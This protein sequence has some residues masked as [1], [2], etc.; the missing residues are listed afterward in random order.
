MLGTLEGG[1]MEPDD[2]LMDID[3]QQLIGS[4]TTTFSAQPLGAGARRAPVMGN[5]GLESQHRVQRE[6][7]RSRT[8]SKTFPQKEKSSSR[9]SPRSSRRSGAADKGGSSGS[10]GVVQVAALDERN[11]KKAVH[12][13]GTLPKGAR[14]GAY[15]ESLR[16]SGMTPEPVTEQ[17]VDSDATIDSG[18]LGGGSGADTLERL[19]GGRISQNSGSINMG[20]AV[21][22]NKQQQQPMLR[23]NSSHGGFVS[24]NSGSLGGRGRA[25]PR[26]NPSQLT[27]VGQQG[28]YDHESLG[29][30]RG[31]TI[32]L[33]DLEFPP[34][35]VDLP[36]PPQSFQT[37]Q[38]T[39]SFKPNM[40]NTASDNKVSSPRSNR[41][42][43]SADARENGQTL[44]E[45]LARS[46]LEKRK[47]LSSDSCDS[48]DRS[49]HPTN[50]LPD[51]SSQ[52]NQHNM[53]KSPVSPP[54]SDCR[55]LGSPAVGSLSSPGSTFDEGGRMGI[56]RESSSN[57]INSPAEPI[58]PFNSFAG[59]SH[60]PSVPFGNN[61]NSNMETKLLNEIR[62]HSASS[63]PT[64][65][66]PPAEVNARASAAT[67]SP[68][69]SPTHNSNN[70]GSN[71]PAAMLVTELFETIKAKSNTP[72]NNRI[73]TPEK[74]VESTLEDDKHHEIDFKANLRKVKKPDTKDES[75]KNVTPSTPK[76]IDF[77]SQ[78]K[79]TESTYAN[80]EISKAAVSTKKENSKAGDTEKSLQFGEKISHTHAT[81]ES[82]TETNPIID[83][84]SKLRKSTSKPDQNSPSQDHTNDDAP[85]NFQ[86][87][88]RKVSGT[89]KAPNIT[90]EQQ[91]I[92][93]T[94]KSAN[95]V[96]KRTTDSPRCTTNHSLKR[97][98]VDS[99]DSGGVGSEPGDDKRKSTGSITS[100][101]KMWETGKDGTS[102]GGNSASKSPSNEEAT[103]VT[104]QPKHDVQDNSNLHG[105]HSTVKFEKR[106]WPPVPNTETEK[107][108][109]PVKPTVKPTPAPPTT[110]P[111]PPKEPAPTS[112][113]S[114]GKPSPPGKPP[115]AAKP[116]VCNIYAAPTTITTR[117]GKP[118]TTGAD[119]GTSPFI[120]LASNPTNVPVTSSVPTTTA[121]SHDT[122]SGGSGCSSSSTSEKEGLEGGVNRGALLVNCH[123]LSD[124]LDSTSSKLIMDEKLSKSNLMQLSEQVSDVY[125][126][127]IVYVD[128]IPA[129]GRF[130]YRSLCNKLEDQSKELRELSIGN[131][132]M[133]RSNIG[134]SSFSSNINSNANCS[135][136]VNDIQNTIK[137]L[138]NVIQR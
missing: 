129:T 56:L 11:L 110:K 106:V 79:K 9:G 23:S 132:K 105:S 38:Q 90:D 120:P 68:G 40:S 50:A 29:P 127:A 61:Q 52:L 119:T 72:S 74:M 59:N 37:F 116:N 80:P 111:P 102:K 100:L 32:A 104:Q 92:L 10:S 138:V 18:S 87:R 63:M 133:D 57:R 86:A 53:P 84:K 27:R 131:N 55:T 134:G 48:L 136:V 112:F 121:V 64:R 95:G 62:G 5:R 46:T 98:S 8:K 108:M 70:D 77:K 22:S 28:S 6:Q 73:P 130:R 16:Q 51:H 103:T 93:D 88:L 113:R 101:R 43:F 107:P 109:V 13:Y 15:L 1:D 35:P 60:N 94:K 30:S 135:D 41:R 117:R 65:S 124:S 2:A 91:S 39:S 75:D 128:N 125:S 123:N 67:K 66:P 4:S 83:F 71:N 36:P 76:H 114:L 7:E 99:I 34:P 96:E 137:G 122:H 49:Y 26:T 54:L 118:T 17:G 42:E 89:S 24:N 19:Q 12:R 58:R 85:H 21:G 81:N 97:D 31:A 82:K 115:M 47:E 44:P 20:G 25:S 14:I 3:Q 69:N 78:L 126:A 33:N 45:L